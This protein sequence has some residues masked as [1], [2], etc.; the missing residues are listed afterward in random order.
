MVLLLTAIREFIEFSVIVILLIGVYREH[1]RFLTASALIIIILGFLLTAINYPLTGLLEKAYTGFMF[2]SFVIV[3]FLSFIAD[4]R[5]IYPLIALLLSLLLPSAQLAVVIMREASLDGYT[6]YVSL[7][8]GIVISGLIFGYAKRFVL[9]FN[10]RNF[11]DTRGVMVSVANFCFIFGG[12]N[13]FGK[14]SQIVVSIHRGIYNFL[15]SFITYFREL[16]LIPN[17][18][19]IRMPFDPVLDYLMSQRVAMALTA[20]MLFIPPLHLFIG[21]LLKPEPST[22]GIERGAEKRKMISAYLDELIKKGSPLLLS[23][24]VSIIMLHSANLQIN[25]LYDPEPIPLIFE[26]DTIEIPLTGMYGDISDGRIRKFSFNYRND[27]YR[28]IVMMRV[29]GKVIATLDACKIC[30]PHGYVQRGG[31]II[32][33]YCSTPIASQSIGESGG[34][35]PI[36]LE[37]EI[38]G[39]KLLLNRN[40]IISTYSK[41]VGGS[42]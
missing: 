6:P 12:L 30:P 39:D 14:D 2:Y 5:I 37:Y 13:E 17:T 26:G 40:H 41:W 1:R 38:R 15:S 34:C 23:L 31:Y 33:K 27:T 21:L 28:V 19:I 24:I 25:P 3:L 18:N 10:I 8:I 20:I 32:C 11:F 29:D 42:G 35:N 16:L 4:E 22:I 36:P 9:R 7:L